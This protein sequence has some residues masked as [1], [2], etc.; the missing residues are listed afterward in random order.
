MSKYLYGASIQ[1]IQSFI[2]ET[3]KLKE[4]VGASELV[5]EIC[6]NF[7]ARAM[8]TKDL[9]TDT[10]AIINAAGNIKYLFGDKT[11]CESI[12]KNFPK[13]IMEKAPGITISQT[14]IEI[15]DKLTAEDFNK[16]EEKLKIQR[17]K[18]VKPLHQALMI[19][20]RARKTGKAGVDWDKKAN[21]VID[22]AQILKRDVVDNSVANLSEKLT[23]KKIST[24]DFTY[25]IEDI[26]V[27]QK[28]AKNW[29]AVVHA[30]GN[31]LGKLIQQMVKSLQ[32]CNETDIKFAFKKFS[33]KLDEAT[34]CAAQTAYN[35]VVLKV[36]KVSKGPIRP[37]VLGGDDLTVIIRGDLALDFTTIFLKQFEIET[38]E[39]FKGLGEKFSLTQFKNGLTACAGISYVKPTY[40]F[41]YAVDLADE[42]CGYAKTVS[43]D[44]V[45]NDEKKNPP[46]CL[47][48]HKVQSS[49]IGSFK[50]DII[51]RELKAGDISFVNGPYFINAEA[52]QTTVSQLKNWINKI[53]S[54]DAPKSALR[55]W[56][57]ELHH[58]QSSAEQL[59]ERIIS[60]NNSYKKKLKLDN[61]IK[62]NRTHLHD[63]L[64]L[65]N[66]QK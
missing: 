22:V 8:Q 65:S 59:M 62:N 6:T 28:E 55:N 11:L 36:E 25:K 2:F 53:N 9:L 46:S 35:E 10:N 42:L 19:S 24:K 17:N 47:M 44:L 15:E 13:E 26:A 43:K 61:E 29:I 51:P 3:N 58:S 56:I 18:V 45:K 60:L 63:V 30:D 27:G 12:V 40:P 16:L 14:V 52:K 49:F 1:G 57:G 48:F 31:N 37:V 7:F 50:D 54:E 4:I 33:Q 23:G 21:E 39:K 66:I 38:A 41:H 64:A 32:N 20:E 34:T 5:E